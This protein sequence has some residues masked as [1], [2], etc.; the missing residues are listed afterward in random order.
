MLMCFVSYGQD[1]RFAPVEFDSD[2][3]FWV[4]K[5]GFFKVPSDETWVIF[6]VPTNVGISFGSRDSM[7]IPYFGM[8]GWTDDDS[9]V[10]ILSPNGEHVLLALTPPIFILSD[11]FFVV[12]VEDLGSLCL[13]LAF[14]DD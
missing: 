6:N 3:I 5:T 13:H 12:Y 4:D 14:R 10:S 7:P 9:L 1:V 11:T 2:S 8:G